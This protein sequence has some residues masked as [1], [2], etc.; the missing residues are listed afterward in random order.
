[1]IQQMRSEYPVRELCKIMEI[2]PSGYYQWLNHREQSAREKSNQ[3]LLEKIKEI[4]QEKHL[5]CYGSPRM[6]QELQNRGYPC[7]RNRVARLMSEEGISARHTRKWKPKTTKQNPRDKASPNHL[8]AL[9]KIDSPGKVWVSDIT[10]VFT[11]SQTY[12][13]AVVMDL[14]TRQIMGWSLD[15]HMESE[16]V[17]AAVKQAEARSITTVERI[18]HSDRGSQYS[19]HLIR[20]HLGKQPYQQSMSALGYCYDNAACESFFATLKKESFPQNQT[21]ENPIEARRA[22]FSY[23]ESFYNS[24]RLHSSLGMIS[25]DEFYQLYLQSN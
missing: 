9:S 17:L 20:D 11:R 25:P 7:S 22:I 13:L 4:H 8:K 1:M 19:S 23:L 18:F 3:I 24:R 10:Y 14:Y 15:S 6:T 12:Y 16:L 21:F 2:S 5:A